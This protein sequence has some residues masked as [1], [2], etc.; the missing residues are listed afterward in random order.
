MYRILSKFKITN[1]PYPFYYW[2]W[3][4]E[5]FEKEYSMVPT[6]HQRG[7]SDELRWTKNELNNMQLL[8]R[9]V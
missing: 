6:S 1:F 8:E 2:D 7:S 4:K 9:K 5:F 3:T